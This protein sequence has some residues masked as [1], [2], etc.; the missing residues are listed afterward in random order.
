MPNLTVNGVTYNFPDPGTPPG[1]GEAATSWAEA[2]TEVLNSLVSPG[3][4]INI[5]ASINNNVTIATNVTGCIFSS[6]QT[7]A[8][9]V[10]YQVVRSVTGSN[11]SETGTLLLHFDPTLGWSLTRSFTGGDAGIDFSVSGSGQVQYT[12]SNLSGTSYEGLIKFNA[13]TLPQV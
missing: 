9:N 4:L 5:T 10:T 11:I 2:V 7:R 8:A 3:D 12:S 6:V 13:K 1:W